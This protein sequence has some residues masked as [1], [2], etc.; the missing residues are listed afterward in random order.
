MN[1]ELQF[2]NQEWVTWYIW[3]TCA[4]FTILMPPFNVACWSQPLELKPVSLF[5]QG[6]AL[7]YHISGYVG[8]SSQYWFISSCCLIIFY[9]PT[10]HSYFCFPTI[11]SANVY[12]WTGYA[13][14][15]RP[16]ADSPWFIPA[17]T[18]T[19][20]DVFVYWSDEHD[21]RWCN[22][23]SL[24]CHCWVVA[25]QARSSVLLL[26]GSQHADVGDAHRRWEVRRLFV[27]GQGWCNRHYNTLRNVFFCVVV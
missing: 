20:R 18:Q 9:S 27:C 15:L 7:D 5:L 8:S 14:I 24:S 2:V 1:L 16:V 25:T 4:T 3:A 13:C 12:F 19:K 21:G 6:N 26:K 17:V 11:Q 22:I 10:W 23:V